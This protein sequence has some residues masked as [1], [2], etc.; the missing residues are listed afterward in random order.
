MS[1]RKND[2]PCRDVPGR[3]REKINR[4]LPEERDEGG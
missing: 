1:S 4:K 3:V 2:E